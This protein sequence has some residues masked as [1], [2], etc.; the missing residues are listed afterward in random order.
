MHGTPC[1]R[2]L[3]KSTVG[4]GLGDDR[5]KGVFNNGGYVLFLVCLCLLCMTLV[6][7]DKWGGL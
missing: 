5:T 6:M 3:E 4:R 1:R 2:I 7:M